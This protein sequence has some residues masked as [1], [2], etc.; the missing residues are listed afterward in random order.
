[1]SWLLVGRVSRRVALR[2]GRS[3]PCACFFR[4]RAGRRVSAT[5]AFMILS[6]Q[7]RGKSAFLDRLD[8]DRLVVLAGI[9]SDAKR[10]NQL[11]ALAR[12]DDHA[13]KRGNEPPMRRR[14]KGIDEMRAIL[15]H[16]D[17]DEPSGMA[18]CDAG[19]GLA[20]GN[21][22]AERA[23]IV[24]ALRADHVTAAIDHAA[25]DRKVT[26]RTRDAKG[27]LDQTVGGFEI[28]RVHD[29][30]FGGRLLGRQGI[31]RR[32]RPKP[33]LGWLTCRRFWISQ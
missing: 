9:T 2:A 32:S 10:S 12:A 15:G 20:V 8:G 16:G 28:D 21:L 18:E 25:G 29:H 27:G 24:L 22:E 7:V 33:C 17:L 19:P 13:A 4:T 31:S 6:A 3:P 30:F 14:R 26:V 1:P 23:R 5:S 11:T